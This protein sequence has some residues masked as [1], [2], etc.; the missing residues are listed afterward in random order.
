VGA[1]AELFDMSCLTGTPL[2]TTIQNDA[3][4]IWDKAPSSF[5]TQDIIKKICR[6]PI[7]LGQHYFVPNPKPAAGSPAISPKWDFTHDAKNGN[8]AAY[9]IGAKVASLAA[10]T[11]NLA[12]VDWL[13]LKSIDG[14]LADAI[15]RVET[16]GGQSPASVS[17]AGHYGSTSLIYLQCTT[18]A[19]PLS[20]KY[21]SQYCECQ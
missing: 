19:P 7:V 14:Q 13:Q 2:S 12:D 20:V 6:N 11:G 8:A 3:F 1:V 17:K 4:T 9:V 5:T 15:Y 18:G 16:K 10:P 21:T